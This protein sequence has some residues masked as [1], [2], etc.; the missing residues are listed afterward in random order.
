MTSCKTY[1]RKQGA[2]LLAAGALLSGSA[3]ADALGN[4]ND[5]LCYGLTAT[6]CTIDG[7]AC[8]T[9]QPWELN[10]PDFVN[11]DL[12]GRLLKSTDAALEQRETEIARVERQDGLIFLQGSQNSRAFSW[13]MSEETG[14]GTIMINEFNVG[15]T[16]FTVCTP[17]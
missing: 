2:W 4:N 3:F 7:D 10:L 16:V 6:V 5:L 14:E 9:K 13:V 17:R 12:R 1:S 11:V 15:I 8:E